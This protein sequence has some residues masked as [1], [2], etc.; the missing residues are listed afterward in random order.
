MHRVS[1]YRAVD[2]PE[3][4]VEALAELGTPAILKTADFGYDGKGQVRI[5]RADQA[6]EAWSHMGRPLG[7]LEAFVPFTQEASVICARSQGGDITCFGPVLNVHAR[8]ILDV[9]TAPA[10]IPPTVERDALALARA[11]TEA[12]GVVGL[13]AVEMFVVG[14]HV[15][16]NELAPRPHNS[17]QEVTEEG[18]EEASAFVAR[19]A[20][21]ARPESREGSCCQGSE[22]ESREEGNQE[23]GYEEGRP[24]GRASGEEAV[25]KAR[26]TALY[27]R[28]P[29]ATGW[30]RRPPKANWTD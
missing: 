23:E 14:E 6:E 5:D 22:Y 28:R 29:S 3:C 27:S 25:G 8:H 4:L 20:G 13:L 16:V 11:I 2:G 10:D 30:R 7:V 21:E 18:R 24:K 17:G 26:L 15:L 19:G 1:P 12:L 9:T